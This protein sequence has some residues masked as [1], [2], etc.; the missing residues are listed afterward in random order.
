[1]KI[2]SIY[3]DKDKRI[4]FITSVLCLLL[5][6]IFLLYYTFEV[7]DPPPIVK[8]LEMKLPI[9]ALSFD[10]LKVENSGSSGGGKPSNAEKSDITRTEAQKVI[11]SK[12]ENNTQVK[13][14]ES[15]SSPSPNPDKKAT[16]P[17]PKPNPF[18]GGDQ[19]IQ[20]SGGIGKGFGKDTGP[21][22]GSNGTGRGNG[23]AG[24][25]IKRKPK[26]K[27]YIEI[28]SDQNY[29]FYF[30]LEI[31]ERG[32]VISGSNISKTT[33][34]NQIVIN[35]VLSSVIQQIKFTPKPGAENEIIEY[36][37]TLRAE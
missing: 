8:P 13:S 37:F 7:A 19:G 1:M 18:S 15:T 33:T 21:D 11:T 31:D 27:P 28:E 5:T 30:K 23:E 29:T 22:K 10:N 2:E 17:T 24:G 16:T 20:N 32:N 34:T 9:S 36:S 4:G 6:F 12:K 14:G 26:N 3:K 25:D 35:K